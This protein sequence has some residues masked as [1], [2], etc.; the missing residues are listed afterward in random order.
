MQTISHGVE[1][2]ASERFRS[3]RKTQM[4]VASGSAAE[5]EADLAVLRAWPGRARLRRVVLL[6]LA[7][8]V[9]GITAAAAADARGD[10]QPIIGAIGA[11][12]FVVLMILRM[13][14]PKR[15]EMRRIELASGLLRRLAIGPEGGRLRLDLSPIGLKRKKAGKQNGFDIFNDPFLEIDVALAD[16]A[17]VKVER[18]EQLQYLEIR[19]S[20]RVTRQ[21]RGVV[22]DT[23]SVSVPGR[24]QSDY[25]EKAPRD[26]AHVDA[27]ALTLPQDFEGVSFEAR[28]DSI[29][30]VIRNQLLWDAVPEGETVR[31]K[32][33]DA[34]QTIATWLGQLG[35]H[36]Q[37]GITTQPRP[38][39]KAKLPIVG[40]RGATI[41]LG[42]ITLAGFGLTLVSGSEMPQHYGYIDTYGSRAFE[43]DVIRTG[44][45]AFVCC[46]LPFA[47]CLGVVVFV[48][49][50]RRAF[51][52]GATGRPA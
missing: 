9:A 8:I 46:L 51:E 40:P 35:M 49:R 43:E 39:W 30:V 6:V 18:T 50:R 20:K 29:R 21:W 22:W 23:I 16:G 17:R 4:H 24:G 15:V 52:A 34:V 42:M 3:F 48:R 32:R 7:L 36:A 33:N 1:R 25:R 12:V 14:Q 13:R 19:T 10:D 47:A 37:L 44:A 27:S 26:L 31:P 2:F 28:S 38:A 45:F 11:F 5:L 41:V